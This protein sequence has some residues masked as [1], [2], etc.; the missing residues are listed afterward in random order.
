MIHMV[1]EITL[2]NDVVAG[3]EKINVTEELLM[4]AIRNLLGAPIT[5]GLGGGIGT[6][7]LNEL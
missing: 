2:I 5:S 6:I 7:L 1:R 3:G 4:E